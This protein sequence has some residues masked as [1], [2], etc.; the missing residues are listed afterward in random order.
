VNSIHPSNVDTPM[1]MNDALFRVFRPDLENP[2]IDDAKDVLQFLNLM[3][4]P[5]LEVSDISNA[6]VFLASDEGRFIT[7]VSLPIDAGGSIK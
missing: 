1:I 7:G 5:Y 2:S 4:V 3:P 6:V